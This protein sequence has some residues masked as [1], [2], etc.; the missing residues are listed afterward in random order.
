[1]NTQDLKT[2]TNRLA[3]IRAVISGDLVFLNRPMNDVLIDIKRLDLDPIFV[4]LPVRYF[5]AY[6]I[7]S[8]EEKIGS[9]NIC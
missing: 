4:D 1:M 9:L 8:L 5:N 6:H 3:F 2:L 7:Q